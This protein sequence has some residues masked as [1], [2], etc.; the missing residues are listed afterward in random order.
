MAKEIL[1]LFRVIH[2]FVN[3][4]AISYLQDTEDNTRLELRFNVFLYHK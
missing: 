4:S 1:R 3:S 2:G